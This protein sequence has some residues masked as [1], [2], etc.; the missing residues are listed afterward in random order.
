MVDRRVAADPTLPS[1]LRVQRTLPPRHLLGGACSALTLLPPLH[2]YPER[3]R[4]R[5]L[6]PR[7][8]VSA[9]ASAVL[10]VGEGLGVANS[11]A[12]GP[13]AVYPPA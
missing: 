2:A 13:L 8:G 12:Q 6:G 9:D 11:G 1:R 7:T 3:A 10:G 5:L 4:A